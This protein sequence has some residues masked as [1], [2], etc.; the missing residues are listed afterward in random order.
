[1]DTES[2]VHL[3]VINSQTATNKDKRNASKYLPNSQTPFCAMATTKSSYNHSKASQ[4]PPRMLNTAPSS[5]DMLPSAPLS[6]RTGKR[7]V[8]AML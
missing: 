6:P 7:R 1:M 5:G 2:P 4:R 3:N 8:G